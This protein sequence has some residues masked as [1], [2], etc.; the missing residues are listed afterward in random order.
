MFRP[1]PCS[2]YPLC[3]QKKERIKNSFLFFFFSFACILSCFN[4]VQHFVTPWTV[5]HQ[6]PL[7]LGFSRQ[8]DWSGLPFSS[9]GYLPHSGIESMS[10][11]LAGR[12]FIGWA[13]REALFIPSPCNKFNQV[14]HRQE[15]EDRM[16]HLYTAKLPS[17]ESEQ[18]NA[19]D[20]SMDG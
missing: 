1:A 14:I 8:E 17:P 6:A 4:H 12:F 13:T 5:P 11:A 9:P 18:N 16:V 3:S 2:L 7:S 10:P 20:N 19:S 15:N